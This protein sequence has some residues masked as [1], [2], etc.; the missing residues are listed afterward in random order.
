VKENEKISVT[1][2]GK[3]EPLSRIKKRALNVRK[4]SSGKNLYRR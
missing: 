3:K 2:S 4:L 1:S